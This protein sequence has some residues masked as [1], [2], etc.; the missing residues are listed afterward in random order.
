MPLENTFWPARFGVVVDQFSIRWLI[1]CDGSSALEN[2]G[3]GWQFTPTLAQR[4]QHAPA[5][6]VRWVAGC[7]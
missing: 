4:R 3:G 5:E 1:N 2:D 7:C 6:E